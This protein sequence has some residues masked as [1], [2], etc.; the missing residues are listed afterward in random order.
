M[1]I[2]PFFGR[3][4]SR[5]KFNSLLGSQ[6]SYHQW[7]DKDSSMS[8]TDDADE[9]YHNIGLRDMETIFSSAVM[10][11]AGYPSIA[12]GVSTTST[13]AHQSFSNTNIY[14]TETH[15][16][17]SVG[18]NANEPD[19]G[20][21][22]V[23]MY[24][25]GRPQS[26]YPYFKPLFDMHDNY[27][28]RVQSTDGFPGSAQGFRD[29][30]SAA[31]Q[32]RYRQIITMTYTG[33]GYKD[34]SPWRHIHRTKHTNDQTTNLG[35]LM[36]H[37]GSYTGGMCNDTTF[38]MLSTPTDN[39]H[40]TNSSRTS[41]VHMWTETGKSHNSVFDMY[42][43]RKDLGV[44]QKEQESAFVTGDGPSTWDIFNLVTEVRV[45]QFGTGLN[46]T[47]SA[48]QDKD[49]GYHWDDNEGRKVNFY[50][51]SASSSTQ[52]GAHGQ[53]KG[54][55][56]KHRIGYAGNEG[57]YNGGYNYRRWNL[58]NDTN[59]GT[60]GKIQQNMGEENYGMG[61]D[62]QYMI[63]NYDGAQNN[64]SHKLY[65]TTDTGPANTSNPTANGGQSSGH[66]GWRS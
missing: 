11:G 43:S 34:G 20:I 38:F 44:S 22:R 45:A 26:L 51:Y 49:R 21:N 35:T 60:I 1:S 5:R 42:N 3:K 66:C 13:V 32:W 9:G 17:G 6:E 39:A 52:W 50:T 41:A 48:F 25:D 54:I 56:S 40:S 53:Q 31:A 47:S 46:D 36:D 30:N 61:Q 8:S 59:I 33:G 14:N 23:R 65:Y 18:D 37:P 12:R 63:G 55:P 2:G 16:G 58:T 4:K 62:W 10:A 57:S 24:E 29:V 27:A 7:L 15:G 19:R 28:A 64:E